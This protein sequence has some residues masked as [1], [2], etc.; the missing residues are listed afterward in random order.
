MIKTVP[1]EEIE[2]QY[3]YMNKIK[4]LGLNKITFILEI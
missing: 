1:Q 3:E 4:S 2:K